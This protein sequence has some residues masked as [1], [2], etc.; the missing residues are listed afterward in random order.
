MAPLQER[1][2][3]DRFK[4]YARGGNCGNGC[5]SVG[6]VGVIVMEDLMNAGQGGHGA[7]KNKIGTR[8]THKLLSKKGIARNHLV[9]SVLCD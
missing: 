7:S 2:M 8:G 9:P 5:F 6:R 1:R 4:L 3:I